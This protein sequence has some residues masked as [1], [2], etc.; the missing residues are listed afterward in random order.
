MRILRNLRCLWCVNM[1][2]SVKRV[3]DALNS[4]ANSNIRGHVDETEL[5]ALIDDYFGGCNDVDS[6]LSEDGSDDDAL[7]VTDSADTELQ[8]YKSDDDSDADEARDES[9]I[10]V[11][12]AQDVLGPAGRPHS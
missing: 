5:R 12:E 10:T 2:E 6:E 9:L 4:L 11:S 8:Y 7:A 1:A 3:A